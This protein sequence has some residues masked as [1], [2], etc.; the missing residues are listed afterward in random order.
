M[1]ETIK[2]RP[3]VLCCDGVAFVVVSMEKM[4]YFSETVRPAIFA[5]SLMESTET[6]LPM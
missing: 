4:N 3:E 2:K 6:F 5:I 1:E